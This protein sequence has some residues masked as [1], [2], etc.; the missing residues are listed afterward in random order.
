MPR[1]EEPI[2]RTLNLVSFIAFTAALSSRAVDPVIPQLATALLVEPAT[3]AM[4]SAAFALSYGF[5]QPV[6]GPIADM[7]GKTRVM[8]TCLA[9]LLVSSLLSAIVTSFAVL[10]ALRVI[11][12]AACGGTFPVALAL[13]GDHVPVSQRQVAIGR[14]LAAT[15]SGNLLGSAVSGVVADAVHWRGVFVV[16]AGSAAVALASA[17]IGFRHSPETRSQGLAFRSVPESFRAILANPR[18]RVCYSVVLLEGVFLF[19]V[20]P[21]VAVLLHAAG[22]R[23]ALIAGLVLASFALGGLVYSLA[24]RTLLRWLDQLGLMIAGGALM[25]IGL[26]CVALA[27]PWPMQ[28]LAFAAIGCGFYMLHAS[29]QFYVTEIAP[30]TRASA[31]AFHTL[32]FSI[33]QGIGPVAFGIGLAYLGAPVSLVIAAVAMVLIGSLGA[34]LLRRPG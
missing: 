21:Y 27:P 9:V 15:I 1:G 28:C 34:Q 25:A 31:V 10:L 14:L 11:G 3:A 32:S 12:G 22:E 2:D 26:V 23:R 20:F 16:L 17:I 18:A 29:I 6:L 7:V 19:G 8:T 13:L 24:V 5:V 30:S 4:L 33:G